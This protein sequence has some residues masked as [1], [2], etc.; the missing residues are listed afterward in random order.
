M[1]V[2][3]L[4]LSHGVHDYDGRW[5][6]W[7][8]YHGLL[9]SG[10]TREFAQDSWTRHLTHA[11]LIATVETRAWEQYDAE[12]ERVAYVLP[13]DLWREIRARLHAADSPQRGFRQGGQIGQMTD[14][15]GKD[16]R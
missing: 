3:T 10:P 12:G 15:Y 2:G 11:C 1:K 4:D 9:A 16:F 8:R 14:P 6:A 7:C 13:M 5:V